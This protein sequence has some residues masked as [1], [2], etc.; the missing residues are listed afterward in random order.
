MH[1]PLLPLAIDEV[2]RRRASKRPLAES[3][4]SHPTRL[5]AASGSQHLFCSAEPQRP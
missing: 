5:P 3:R 1:L 4:T 2:R